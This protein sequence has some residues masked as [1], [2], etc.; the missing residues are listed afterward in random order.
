MS[1]Q[2]NNL[3]KEMLNTTSRYIYWYNYGENSEIEYQTLYNL[4]YYFTPVCENKKWYHTLF[5][6]YTLIDLEKRADNLNIIESNTN[7]L[8]RDDLVDHLLKSNFNM[9]K[10][11]Y[12]ALH[13]KC[14]IKS[15]K[16]NIK[17]RHEVNCNFDIY[18]IHADYWILVNIQ[19]LAKKNYSYI[20]IIFHDILTGFTKLELRNISP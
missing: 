3:M 9:A 7:L 17:Y 5:K 13:L 8:N 12:D 20:G 4:G 2:L 15:Q 11:I 19:N 10:H 6:P 16:F 18:T 1:Q 14:N